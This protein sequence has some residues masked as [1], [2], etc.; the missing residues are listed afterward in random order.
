[1]TN[2][3]IPPAVERALR[4]SLELGYIQTTRTE[5]GRLLA[6][7]AATCTDTIAEC[8]TGTG[9]GAAWLRS[10]APAG[11]RVVTA[12]L[13]PALAGEAADAVSGEGI[14]VVADAFAALAD[15]GPF[16][17]LLA[18]RTLAWDPEDRNIAARV[19]NPGGMIVIDDLEPSRGWPPVTDDGVDAQRQGWLMDDRFTSAE[20]MVA[21]DAAVL[22]CVRR[23][24]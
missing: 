20:V 17:L 10:G 21:P 15:E 16:D 4:K 18:D 24:D 5:T 8:G 19:L 1:M 9:V 12:E 22:I 3:T 11:I 23:R 7:L 2:P 13:D 6:A 14:E